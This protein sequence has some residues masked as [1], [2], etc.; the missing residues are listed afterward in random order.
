MA[1]LAGITEG[2]T[3]LSPTAHIVSPW[4]ISLGYRTQSKR[5]VYMP[6]FRR[7]RTDNSPD[8]DHLHLQ[9]DVLFAIS[10]TEPSTPNKPRYVLRRLEDIIG[11]FSFVFQQNVEEKFTRNFNRSSFRNQKLISKIEASY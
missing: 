9:S 1:R 10:V 2:M 4:Y 7:F 5:I 8:A 3:P 6:K 11:L